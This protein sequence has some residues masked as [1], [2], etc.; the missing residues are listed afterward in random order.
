MEK[1]LALFWVAH[2]GVFQYRTRSKPTHAG[3]TQRIL[4]WYTIRY[5][6]DTK[7]T[8]KFPNACFVAEP[9]SFFCIPPNMPFE[10]QSQS[11]NNPQ[12]Y[13]IKFLPLDPVLSENLQEVHPPL[14]ADKT[15]KLMLDYIIDHWHLQ[16]S[17]VHA[18]CKDFT[19]TL[20]RLLS[21]YKLEQDSYDSRFIL[22]SRYNKTTLIT[23]S[24]IEKNYYT[25]FSLD[26]L[27]KATGY[28]RGYLCT[29]FAKNTG[30]SITTYANYL[31]IRKA[32]GSIL[33]FQPKI[34]DVSESLGFNNLNYFSQTFKSFVGISPHSFSFVAKRMTP[35]DR[36]ALWGSESFLSYRRC[37]LEDEL[38]SMRHIGKRFAALYA[39]L[40][41]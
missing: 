18:T 26:D 8:I 36:S 37:A 19:G 7:N 16:D 4:R 40:G 31:R 39:E 21:L 10:V 29:N 25:H 3:Q 24:F 22:T 17:K 15:T 1:D 2:I 27:A 23:L 20:L 34:T 13:D 6:P 5:F 32:I 9:G 35:E 33:H 11:G 28:S 12:Y 30:I 14:K 41:Q 38:A